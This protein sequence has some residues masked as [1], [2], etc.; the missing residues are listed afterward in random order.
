MTDKLAIFSL[1]EDEQ[2]ARLVTTH[3]G[4]DLGMIV[5]RVFADG[6]WWVQYAQSIRGH[7]VYIIAS[8]YGRPPGGIAIR[9]EHLKQLVRAAKLASCAKINVVCP[10]F[11]CRGDFKDRPRVDI[12]ARRWA[13]EMNEAG[14]SRL[15]TMELH[16]N[17]VVGFFAPTPVDHLYPSKTFQAH[18]TAKEIS[19]LIIVAADAGGVKRVE[20]YADYLDAK[21]IAIITKRRK[22]PNKVEHMR[23]TGDVEGKTCLIVEDVIDTAGTFELSVQKL[24]IAKAEKVYGFGIHP[25]FSDQAV[26]RLQSC[27]LHQLIVTNTIPLAAKYDGIEVLDI[28]EVFAN[29][30]IAA[31][32]NQPIDELF[33]ENKGK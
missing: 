32:N 1:P 8:L 9:F 5:P 31:H 20:N 26:Q 16:S 33:L 21:D 24:K 27:G 13:D 14:I 10:Y 6:N 22:Q 19:N 29:A 30:I 23:L 12:M 11:E 28:S 7:D 3:I 4:I 15:I 17:P 25:L 18:F 2:F